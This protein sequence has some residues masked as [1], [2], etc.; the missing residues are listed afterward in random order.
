MTIFIVWIVFICLERK[1]NWNLIKMYVK[2]K[3]FCGTV[4]PLEGVKILA[5]NLYQ[6]FDNAP[7]CYLCKSW[8]FDKKKKINAK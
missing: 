1:I 5:F 4:K 7:I 6:K 2:A 8:I 3:A